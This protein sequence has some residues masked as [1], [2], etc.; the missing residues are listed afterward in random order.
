[1]SIFRSNCLPKKTKLV[2]DETKEVKPF[3]H[4]PSISK[5][6]NDK[7]EEGNHLR[8]NCVNLKNMMSIF[9]CNC[10]PRKT[11]LVNDITVK[12]GRQAE[13]NCQ[14]RPIL[15]RP[16]SRCKTEKLEEALCEVAFDESLV[17]EKGEDYVSPL[18]VVINRQSKLGFNLL[19]DKLCRTEKDKA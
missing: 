10:L 13:P 19:K 5:E 6:I 8:D 18:K 15:Q 4:L 16:V 11:K 14:G 7:I 12:E 17:F 3:Q 2:N 9:K 1:M